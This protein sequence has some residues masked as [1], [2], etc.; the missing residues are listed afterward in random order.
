MSCICVC[1]CF[2]TLAIPQIV[3]K[4]EQLLSTNESIS[5]SC[6]AALPTL[7]KW[8]HFCWE[9]LCWW[10][11][12]LNVALGVFFQ[13]L[14][15]WPCYWLYHPVSIHC[16]KHLQSNAQTVSMAAICY[17]LIYNIPKFFF[18]WNFFFF[19]LCIP[20]LPLFVY[21][22]LISLATQVMDVFSLPLFFWKL[23]FFFFWFNER[24]Y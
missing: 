8:V 9:P 21:W 1:L 5:Q 2:V 19:K 18:S 11:G 14:H 24:N 7:P 16:S 15:S 6:R 22:K 23:I 12:W 4:G 3:V 10:H 17:P 20:P 13:C